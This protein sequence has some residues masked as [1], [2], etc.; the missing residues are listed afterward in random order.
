MV[1]NTQPAWA[2]KLHK[3]LKRAGEADCCIAQLSTSMC[4]N[5]TS[6]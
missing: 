2:D 4:S 6:G 5:V 1:K 3:Q